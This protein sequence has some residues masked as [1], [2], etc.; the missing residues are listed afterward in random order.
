LHAFL[1]EG[2]GEEA[3]IVA[4]TITTG[5]KGAAKEKNAH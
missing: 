1:R 2:T 5:L 3:T 4:N